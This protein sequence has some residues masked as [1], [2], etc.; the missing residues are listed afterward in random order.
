MFVCNQIIK[1]PTRISGFLSKINV[2]ILNYFWVF[3]GS[4]SIRYLVVEHFVLF[5]VI[6]FLVPCCDVRYNFHIKICSVCLY[7]KLFVGELMHVFISV[8]LLFIVVSHPTFLYGFHDG[9]HK[10]DIL[11]FL[12]H[13]VWSPKF[14]GVRVTHLLVFCVD[15]SVFSDIYLFKFLAHLKRK[16]N[17]DS[18][19]TYSCPTPLGRVW[20]NAMVRMV[21]C[22]KYTT[23]T[24]KVENLLYCKILMRTCEQM[25]E[26]LAS[27]ALL[28]W[29]VILKF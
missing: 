29:Y 3:P 16:G 27:H 7:P 17:K 25:V 13:L 10:H 2:F 24:L 18:L 5:F 6:T 19:P 23:Y 22:T 1:V 14:G 20:S 8:V 12:D 11:N 4:I 9:C 15:P 26:A 21:S 28:F